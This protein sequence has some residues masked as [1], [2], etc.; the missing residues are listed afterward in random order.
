MLGVSQAD[1]SVR[2]DHVPAGHYRLRIWAEGASEATLNE[3]TRDIVVT[4]D[5]NFGDIRVRVTPSVNL[6]HTNKFGHP[7][8]PVRLL[9]GGHF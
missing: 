4:S 9:Y 6:I 5:M 2:I 7:Y 1:G 3:L 8:D